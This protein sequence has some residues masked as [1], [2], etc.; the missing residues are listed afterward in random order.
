MLKKTCGL[1]LGLV[2]LAGS[3]C[4]TPTH[5]SS[6]QQII[7]TSIQA[8]GAAGAKEELVIL[9]NSSQLAVSVGDWCLVNKADVT[10][11]CF[12]SDATEGWKTNYIVPPYGYLTIASEEYLQ[13]HDYPREFYSLV[14][15]VTNQSSGSIVGSADSLSLRNDEQQLIAE[16]TWVSAIPAGKVLLRMKL[17]TEPDI[18]AINNEATDWLYDT[19]RTPPLS[20]LMRTDNPVTPPLEEEPEEPG[21]EPPHTPLPPIITEVLAN[22]K[23]ADTGGEYIELY[24]PNSSDEVALGTFKLRVGVGAS[25]KWYSF[26]KGMRIAARSYIAILNSQVAFTLGNTAGAVQLFNGDEA[27]GELIEYTSPKEG[28]AWVLL[29]GAWQYSP[30]LTPGAE[31]STTPNEAEVDTTAD[32]TVATAPQKPCAANQ[33]RNP[34]TGRCKLIATDS[35]APSPCKP[36]QERNPETNRCRSVAGAATALTPCKEGQERSAETN[37]CRAIVKMSSV[38]YKVQDVQKGADNQPSWYYWIAIIAVVAM[39]LGY[40]VWEWREELVGVWKRLRGLVRK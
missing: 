35:T 17:I 27:V 12:A 14:Y 25:A 10:F 37:R 33:Y 38:D 15:P 4:V 40:A 34:E 3:A 18:Y 28:R 32:A 22:P 6:A 1:F 36:G 30:V 19:V 29:D 23:G 20:A 21:S 2:V 7:I 8:G 13:A 5:A 16:K 11:A 39:V 26:P 31:N 24:N 9:Y